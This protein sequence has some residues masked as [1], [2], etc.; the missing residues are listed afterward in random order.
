MRDK[1]IAAVL[2]F[3]GGFV[4][5]HR[6]YLGQIGLGILYVFLMF[7]GISFLL[8][9]IDFV[10]FLGM[11]REDFERKYNSRYSYPDYRRRDTDFERRQR[12]YREERVNRRRYEERP[13]RRPAPQR[14]RK[15]A[16]TPKP[17]SP[18]R[19]NPFKASGVEK[20]KDYDYEGAIEDFQ[21]S[22]E[23]NPKDLA[24]HFN[25]ACAYS[26]TEQADQ[27]FYHLDQ[28]VQNGYRDFEKINTHDALAYVRI[29]DEFEV[30]VE[31]GYRLE[32]Q[33]NSSKSSDVSN[34]LLE[35]LRQLGELR[36]RGLLT[37]D[38]FEI[39]KK[40]LLEP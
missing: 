21:K 31:N 20:F 27:A 12:P 37:N 28:A 33:A 17:P 9:L 22:L 16:A 40:R 38:E 32:S 25:I 10:V 13:N 39:Q 26:L 15:P 5:I 23:I 30:F 1:T 8:G 7:T 18:T 11:D 19:R 34:D 29:Q 35:Q 14:H 2:A 3:F 6:F 4:G 24:T 36:E